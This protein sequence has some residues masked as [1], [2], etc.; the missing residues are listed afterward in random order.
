MLKRQV[1]WNYDTGTCG[2]WQVDVAVTS[3][4]QLRFYLRC[5][6]DHGPI[7]DSAFYVGTAD[8]RAA[9]DDFRA[10]MTYCIDLQGK[11]KDEKK[12]S[13]YQDLIAL[14]ESALALCTGGNHPQPRSIGIGDAR[15]ALVLANGRK[16]SGEQFEEAKA[17]LRRL[18]QHATPADVCRHLES[19]HP[20]A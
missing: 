10:M 20:R 2:D 6:R 1:N 13:D 3:T 18:G 19:T 9:L 12:L 15:L 11:V 16:W 17:E 4:G 5:S 14:L 7:L 8:V